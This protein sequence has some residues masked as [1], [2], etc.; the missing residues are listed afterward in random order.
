MQN[1]NSKEFMIQG[2]DTDCEMFRRTLTQAGFSLYMKMFADTD[3]GRIQSFDV[4]SNIDEYSLDKLL[5]D[6]GVS[7]L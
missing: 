2:I 1:T 6:S 5:D 3:E 7:I 4:Q